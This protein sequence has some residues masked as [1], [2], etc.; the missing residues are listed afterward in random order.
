[1]NLNVF[2][3]C[4]KYYL[5]SLSLGGLRWSIVIW[6]ISN[7]LLLKNYI[8]NYVFLGND[9]QLRCS[10]VNK[11]HWRNLEN[12]Y[13]YKHPL[14]GICRI[15]SIVVI[16]RSNFCQWGRIITDPSIFVANRDGCY[17]SGQILQIGAQNKSIV[18][19]SFLLKLKTITLNFEINIFC[20]ILKD[21]FY[22][23]V[24]S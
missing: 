23:Q 19:G 22:G 5:P 17:K 10:Q 15:T 16:N 9:R 14:K 2:Q 18:I 7:P 13:F 12:T 4:R 1:M 11:L 6:D 3:N 21:K 8:E 24:S 20:N